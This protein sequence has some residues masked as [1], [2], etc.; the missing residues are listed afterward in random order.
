MKTYRCIRI[1]TISSF[2]VIFTHSGISS[3]G[4]QFSD[5]VRT[6]QELLQVSLGNLPA[7]LIIRGATVLD[8]F[9]LIWT[10]N[11]DIVIRGER[12]A[13]VGESETWPGKAAKIASAK[14]E[15]AVPGFGESHKHIESSYVTPEYEAQLV[16][17]D[18]N[19]WS[20]EGSHE[21]SNVVGNR[22]VDF[23][24]MAEEHGSPLKIFVGVG[25]AT[26]PTVY[27]KGGGYYGYKEMQRFLEQDP[28]VVGLGEVMDWSSVSVPDSPGHQ[29]IWEVIQAT[30]DSRGVV[31][32]HALGLVDSESI[33][34]F[35][36][37]G[38]SSDHH[39]RLAEEGCQKVRRGI[40]AE[41]HAEATRLL[42]PYLL[43]KGVNS[44]SSL[45]VCTDDR[46]ALA[47]LQLGTMDYNIRTAIESGVPVEAAYAMGSYYPA[48][49]WHLE[50]L[51]GSI[52]PGRYAD[53]VLLKDR[54]KVRI[55][56]VFANGILAAED[57]EYLLKVPK[58]EYPEWVTDTINVGRKL[59]PEDFS[60]SAP[61]GKKEVT[62]AILEIFY[63]GEDFMT[64]KLPVIDGKVPAR[65]QDG[66]SKVAMVDRYHGDAGVAKM[67][68]RN[69]GP[70]NP[71]SALASSN[72]HDLHN[73]WAVGN[74]D[75]AMALAVNTIAGMG[76]GW[77]LVR[78]G[79]VVASVRLEIGG[80]MS[81][82]PVREVADELEGLYKAADAMKWIGR[83]G[84][85]RILDKSFLTCTPW[86]WVLVAPYE[87]NPHGL[88][89]VTTGET[90]P[91]VW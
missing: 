1:G 27:E 53:I 62:A 15:W 64:A 85:P 90:H 63:W 43:E 37:A 57:D 8:V 65:P 41:L 12:I 19:T 46:D 21:L 47:S 17:P 89:K 10:E 87:G 24:L 23:W 18:G 50:H 61:E 80:L 28:R 3:E 42:V 75:S 34:A 31:E 40:F 9:N 2:L 59:K 36:A 29:R 39:I 52:A 69:V 26:P 91:V 60:I 48:Q 51:V 54:K 13:W 5:E 30:L 45:S 70:I 7:D 76:G 78:E 77:V 14:G 67:F 11:Q 6:R 68:W 84:L 20:A 33:N 72:A 49:H 55:G 32:G 38:L 74:S 4:F 83:P 71:D 82:R 56:R 81:Q 86:K 16:I 79:R 88:V 58:I 22:N 66:I 73:I 44:W 25:S 35:A